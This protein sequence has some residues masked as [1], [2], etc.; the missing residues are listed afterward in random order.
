MGAENTDATLH[1]PFSHL[2][3]QAKTKTGWR[4]KKAQWYLKE[5]TNRVI[6][7]YVTMP[8]ERF[9]LLVPVAN[10]NICNLFQTVISA[11]CK[12]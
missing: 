1:H 7:V 10:K 9:N 2:P 11:D 8:K 5:K 4:G 6:K 12:L 3:K